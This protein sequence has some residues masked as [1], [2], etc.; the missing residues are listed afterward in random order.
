MSETSERA[1]PAQ[2][3][4]YEAY[5]HE[6]LKAEVEHG[7]DPGAAGEVGRDWGE[8]AQRLREAA[9]ALGE[10]ATGSEDLWQGE[11]GD[12]LRAVLGRATGWADESA[13][14]A[15]RLGDAIGQQ[16]AAAARARAEMPEP[17]PYDPA[18]LIRDA[19]SGGDIRQ[20]AGLAV[21]LTERREEAEAARQRAVDVLYARDEALRAAVPA[22][23]F[24]APPPLTSAS[25]AADGDPGSR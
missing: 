24:S 15:E 4:R 13:T 23:S 22:E 25:P 8:L 17:V 14:L 12:A 5:R 1:V 10:V 11:G 20:L 16:A 3:R 6:E 19:A 2:H 18:G 21:L 7:N 9:G